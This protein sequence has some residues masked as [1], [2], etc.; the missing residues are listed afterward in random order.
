MRFDDLIKKSAKPQKPL[1]YTESLQAKLDSEM[2]SKPTPKFTA[3]EW[4][5]ME[6]GGSLEEADIKERKRKRKKIKSAA[7]GPG[8]YGWYGYDAG[9]SGDG[10]GVEESYGETFGQ[11]GKEKTKI[12]RKHNIRPGDAEWFKLWFSLPYMT[13]EKSHESK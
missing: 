1:T 5:I 11:A 4:A 6:G 2:S 8:P 12:M 10:G 3:L 13:G 9:Y 7:Y